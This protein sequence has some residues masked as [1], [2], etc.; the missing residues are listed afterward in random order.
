M[1][2]LVSPNQVSFVP[3]KHIQDNIIIAQELAHI[4][5]RMKCKKKFMTIKMDLEK[6]YD[7]LC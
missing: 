2:D 1:T 4:M 3:S 6:A 5:C 7:R